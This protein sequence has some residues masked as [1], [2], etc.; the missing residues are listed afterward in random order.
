MHVLAV[1]GIP[2][3]TGAGVG[4][5]QDPTVR[6]ASIGRSTNSGESGVCSRGHERPDTSSPGAVV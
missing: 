5:T 2:I 6:D 3:E 1:K 4:G